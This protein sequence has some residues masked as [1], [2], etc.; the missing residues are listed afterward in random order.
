M[1]ENMTIEMFFDFWRSKILKKD[2]TLFFGKKFH[3]ME[4]FATPKK[5][6]GCFSKY[7]VPN[8][9]GLFGFCPSGW[10]NGPSSLSIRSYPRSPPLHSFPF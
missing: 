1:S 3:Q 9:T 8:F 10:M 2:F 7:L 5:K 6:K 4:K